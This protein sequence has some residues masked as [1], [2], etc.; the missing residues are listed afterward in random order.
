MAAPLQASPRRRGFV[1]EPAAAVVAGAAPVQMASAA[2][3]GPAVTYKNWST[4]NGTT[5]TAQPGDTAA[6]LS[7][8]YAFRPT[9]SSA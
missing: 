3:M 1:V 7:N 6:S 5:I 9:R 2:A 8:R 4:V